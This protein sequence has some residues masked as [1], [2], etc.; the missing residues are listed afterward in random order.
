MSGDTIN[1]SQNNGYYF[2]ENLIQDSYNLNVIDD[3]GCF[4][5]L[6]FEIN[7]SPEL[8]FSISSYLDT[9]SCYGAS[10]SFISLNA[11]GGTPNYIFQLFDLQ[12]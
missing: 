7:E 5:S 11:S 1:L 3:N 4:H 9:I 10:T 2:L 8:L 12:L 6:D